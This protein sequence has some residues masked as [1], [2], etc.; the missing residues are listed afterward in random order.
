M[1]NEKE[2]LKQEKESFDAKNQD[3][4]NKATTSMI[5]G[6]ISICLL[7][8]RIFSIASFVL[9]I[10]G[11]VK[12]SGAK[13]LGCERN[14]GQAKAGLV[15]SIISLVLSTL[16]VPIIFISHFFIWHFHCPFFI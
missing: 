15:L 8:T 7:F 14:I 1:D 5:L 12:Y 9:A 13:K 2:I 4:E 16:L 3:G 10:I 11:I 6:I